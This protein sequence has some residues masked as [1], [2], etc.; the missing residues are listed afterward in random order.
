MVDHKTTM[1]ELSFIGM[2]LKPQYQTYY[3][4]KYSIIGKFC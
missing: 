4:K 3:I 2:P 1:P